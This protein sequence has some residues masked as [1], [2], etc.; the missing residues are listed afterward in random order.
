MTFIGAVKSG[1]RNYIN[2]TG[3]AA[4]PELWYW[5]LFAIIVVGAFGVVDEWLYPGTQMGA[6]SYLD[7]TVFF[8]AI[9]PTLAVIVRRL[10]DVGSPSVLPPAS[11]H[12]SA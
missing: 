9:S 6:F 8:G 3:E 2:F 11:P 7:M 10:N 1:F 5:L 4:Q 12:P